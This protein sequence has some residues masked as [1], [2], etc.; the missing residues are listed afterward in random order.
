MKTAIIT[1]ASSGIGL[2]FAKILAREGFNLTLIARDTED[3]AEIF[4]KYPQRIAALNI[5]LSA[6]EGI[7]SLCGQIMNSEY[8][9]DVIIN[10]AGFGIYGRFEDAPGEVITEMINLNVTALTQI[11]RTGVI[12]MNDAGGGGILNVASSLAFKTSAGYQAY[13]AT[14]SYVYSLSKS[15]HKT[16]KQSGINV[17]ALCPGRTATNFQRRAGE[18]GS[19]IQMN[20]AQGMDAD[21]VAQYAWRKFKTKQFLIIPGVKNKAA[22]LYYSITNIFGH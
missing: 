5:D 16:C 9:P 12:R 21:T 6:Q 22:R 2:A 13:A 3:L 18:S 14:K 19:E 15:L 1:G 10:A 20:S 17:S 8:A 4:E 11:C 7:L